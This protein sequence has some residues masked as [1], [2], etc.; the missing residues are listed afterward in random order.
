VRYRCWVPDYGHEPE[1][2]EHIQIA[3]GTQKEA[4]EVYLEENFVRFEYPTLV[5]MAVQEVNMKDEPCGDPI[6]YVVEVEQ[7]PSFYAYRKK[8]P[9]PPTPG[10]KDE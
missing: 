8:K 9:T 1:D 5:E 7:V 10:G 6:M 4:A 3:Y 2:G